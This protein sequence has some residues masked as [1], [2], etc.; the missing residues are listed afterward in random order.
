MQ[1]I[2]LFLLHIRLH[3]GNMDLLAF[4]Q[5]ADPN[6]VK[7]GEREHAKEEAKLLDSTI[8]RVVLLLPVAP[9]RADITGV[10]IIADE[11]V[12]VEK[13]KCSRKKR[14]AVTD[15]SGSSHPPKKLKGDHITSIGAATGC[16]SPS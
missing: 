3:S 5:V 11:T 16:K 10:R 9:A 6:N 8:G 14:K 13:P 4:I 15:T 1:T 12:V 7:V 2:M